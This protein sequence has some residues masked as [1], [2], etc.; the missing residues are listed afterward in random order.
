MRNYQK[1][2]P[3]AVVTRASFASLINQ[4]MNISAKDT[5]IRNGYRA[6]GLYP[7]D[8][9]AVDYSKCITDIPT[10]VVNDRQIS[11]LVKLEK[12][13]LDLN[14]TIAD[15]QLNGADQVDCKSRFWALVNVA[16]TS[17]KRHTQQNNEQEQNGDVPKE[18]FPKS[19]SNLIPPND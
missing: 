5:T 12:N 11:L 14:Q 13:I 9:N 19:E 2:H 16:I 15:G 4:T 7:W 17:K 10:E 8:P 6:C 18:H 1:D 3:N